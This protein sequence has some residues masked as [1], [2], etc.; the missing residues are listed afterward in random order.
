MFLVAQAILSG[1]HAPSAGLG[2]ADALRA[3]LATSVMSPVVPL[4]A[5]SLGFMLRSTAGAITSVLG[6]IFGPAIFGESLPVGLKL[7][8]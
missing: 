8:N 4:F 1:Y 6:L 7:L 2:D 5:L 3:V